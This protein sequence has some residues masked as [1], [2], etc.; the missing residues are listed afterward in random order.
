MSDMDNRLV[1][2]I[3][4]DRQEQVK[5]V[6]QAMFQNGE[7]VIED[8]I[9]DDMLV[10]EYEQAIKERDDL[11]EKLRDLQGNN[12]SQFYILKSESD[13]YRT[14]LEQCQRD[15]K[16]L[17]SQLTEEQREMSDTLTIILSHLKEEMPDDDFKKVIDKLTDT[18][19]ARYNLEKF[20]EEK[21][22][23]IELE[24]TKEIKKNIRVLVKENETVK[25]AIEVLEE[26][27]CTSSL[28]DCIE[29]S[30]DVEYSYV[31]VENTDASD[32]AEGH[33]YTKEQVLR[34]RE[35]YWC[36]DDVMR[37]VYE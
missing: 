10:S 19:I 13:S 18:Q 15:K 5:K 25:D 23:V 34:R 3:P 2:I 7:G 35:Q 20:K 4:Q 33:I 28:D 14:Q 27:E 6:V 29:D 37:E 9:V 24:V 30:D 31:E 36:S 17:A 32:D 22:K 16:I 21:Y 12:V 11:A 8:V 1:F 26:C